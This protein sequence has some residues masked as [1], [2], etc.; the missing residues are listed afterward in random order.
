[1]LRFRRSGKDHL[2]G[3][4]GPYAND[5]SPVLRKWKIA[6]GSADKPPASDAPWL[7]VYSKVDGVLPDA[8]LGPGEIIYAQCAVNVQVAG[9]VKLLLNSPKGLKLWIDA[10][11]VNNLTVPLDLTAGKHTITFAIQRS[12]RGPIGLRAE[13][14]TPTGSPAKYTPEG[15][16]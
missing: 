7:T 16:L 13:L 2:L 1:M 15:G 5:E 14:T 4:P 6:P 10:R 9:P 11:P 8:D 3:R 12:Q